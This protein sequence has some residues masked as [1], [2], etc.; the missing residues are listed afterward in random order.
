ML[1]DA[2]SGCRSAA[3]GIGL[4]AG[5]VLTGCGADQTPTAPAAATGPVTTSSAP[6]SGSDLATG[7]LPAEAFGQ[8]AE[9]DQLPL[10]DGPDV[11]HWHHWG[12]GWHGW[13]WGD[14]DDATATEC[15]AAMEQAAAQFG[16]VQDAAGQVA[17]T[18]DGVR[19]V[20]ILAVPDTPG[21]A[22]EHFRDVV[23]AC[24]SVSFGE[25][26]GHGPVNGQVSVEEL[27]GLPEDMAAV[28]VT[29]SGNYS[30]ASWSW[31]VLAGVAQDGDR[32]LALVQMS[33][34]HDDPDSADGD[35]LDPAAFTELLQQAYDVQSGALD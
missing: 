29:F 23:G 5:A 28:R 7:L 1:R 22:V 20:E 25:D 15:H 24:G 35:A 16:G 18:E 27:P 34:D 9:I 10:G 11:D 6:A 14:E 17:R 2:L 30:D 19:T 3:L 21:D 31:T 13:W 4:L 26:H 12:H 32:V 33:H 8:G